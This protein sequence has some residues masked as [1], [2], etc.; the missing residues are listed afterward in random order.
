MPPPS[1]D[2]QEA[3][4]TRIVE[5]NLDAVWRV[6]RRCGVSHDQL[7][8]VVQEVFITAARR[9]RD[10]APG[11]ERAFVVGAAVRVSSNW[12]RSMRRRLEDSLSEVENASNEPSPEASAMRRQGLQLLDGALACMTNLQREVFVLTELEQLT[13][14]EVSE[15]L[16]IPEAAAVSRLRRAREV[17][18]QFCE[19]R[20]QAS[21]GARAPSSGALYDA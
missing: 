18:H 20:E 8:D 6:A 1:T 16:Q 21:V 7:D 4:F 9:L 17:F 14:R 15:Q 3:R 13:A 10:I 19:Q 12:R 11:G 2:P 5:E